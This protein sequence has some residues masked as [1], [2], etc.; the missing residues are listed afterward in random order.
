MKAICITVSPFEASFEGWGFRKRF[1][2][3]AL[4]NYDRV[5]FVSMS[6]KK[7]EGF[8]DRFCHILIK[9][10]SIS[11][12][13]DTL[14]YYVIAGLKIFKLGLRC[15]LIRADGAAIELQAVIGSILSRKPLII[16]FR[17]DAASNINR[18]SRYKFRRLVGA[19]V[20]L[21]VKFSLKH[22]TKVIALTDI[23]KS[24]A[25]KMGVPPSRIIVIPTPIDTVRFNPSVKGSDAISV[26]GSRKK[27]ILLYTGRIR[28]EKRINGLIKALKLVHENYDRDVY[29]WIV[30]KGPF[31]EEEKLKK[32]CN[33]LKISEYV[34]FEGFVNHEDIARYYATADIFVLPSATE[35]LPKSL[36]EAM[37][38]AKPILTTKV[39]GVMNV[40][41]ERS[42]IL[43]RPYDVQ[44]LA[45]A[46]ILL[47][48]NKKLA[49]KLAR[50][51]RKTVEEKYSY[52]AVYH[53]Y[54]DYI[55]KYVVGTT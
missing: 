45:K 17:W 14:L 37:A 4:N 7:Y 30:G 21:I 9:S 8:N 5:Y 26:F 54:K 52:E 12:F 11:R 55:N 3:L 44:N 48:K 18:F 41:D 22:A 33:K 29:L 36:L 10:I 40:I 38:M 39:E 28:P 51:A 47:L 42:A 53:N 35:G 27:K 24:K 2:Q 31:K 19:I 34:I 25:I 43:V 15:D 13:L 49:S 1:I 46:I 16:S 32:L 6:K 20:Y 23:L 50:N